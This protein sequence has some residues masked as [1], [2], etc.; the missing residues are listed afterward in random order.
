MKLGIL[1]AGNVGAA[2]GA[3]WTRSGHEVCFGVR[4]PASEQTL[5]AVA[6]AGARARAG[7][8]ADAAAFGE[9]LV[10]ATPWPATRQALEAAGDLRGKLVIDCTNP[11]RPDLSGLEVGH[12]SSGAELIAGW[13]PGARVV[14]AFNHV[15][16]N[17]MADPDRY[18][19]R[20][21][22]FVAGDDA[23]AKATT[24]E[25]VRA[26]GFEARD[27][28]PL[29]AARWLE[30]LAMLWIHLAFTQAQGRDFAFA[31]ARPRA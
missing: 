29:R 4:S 31:L 5:A 1:G 17:V 16:A 12:T 21:V 10:L 3:A 22:M 26:V 18:G 20:P 19:A 7:T 2:L 27:A 24:L 23:A 9:A 30:P 28:G 6:G 11:L 14:K 8:V 15:G 25:L 13:A